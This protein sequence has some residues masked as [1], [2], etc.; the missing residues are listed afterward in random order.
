MPPKVETKLVNERSTDIVV[1][2]QNLETRAIG[3]SVIASAVSTDHIEVRGTGADAG[4]GDVSFWLKKTGVKPGLYNQFK[5]DAY[6]RIIEASYVEGS[7]SGATDATIWNQNLEA[8]A[9]NF[10]I[11]GNGRVNGSLITGSVT[12]GSLSVTGA[13]NFAALTLDEPL[14]VTSGGT[15]TASV[16]A[17]SFFAG[18]V[19]GLN[20]APDW[21]FIAVSDLPPIPFNSLIGLP[22]TLQLHGITDAYT[23]AQVDSLVSGLVVNL[24]DLDDVAVTSPTLN[25]ILKFNGTSWVN[26]DIGSATILNANN[27]PEIQWN[28]PQTASIRV[29]GIVQGGAFA[30]TSNSSAAVEYTWQHSNGW[31][32]AQL[33]VDHSFVLGAYQDFGNGTLTRDPALRVV[34][35]GSEASQIDFLKP[36]TLID[37]TPS[38]TT[39]SLYNDSGALYWNGSPVATGS[40]ALPVASDTVLGGIKVGAGLSIDGAGVLTATGSV[41][42]NMMTTDT[43]QSVTG[44][45][46]F[47]VTGALTAYDVI[48]ST[49]DI[50]VDY[51]DANSN[52]HAYGFNF[53]FNNVYRA[54]FRWNEQYDR[55]ELNV[56]EDNG[57]SRADRMM[58]PR[59]TALP[60]TFGVGGIQ[61]SAGGV[62]LSSSTPSA[63]ANK[64]YNVSGALYWNGAAIGSGASTLSSLTD[65]ALSGNAQYDALMF[66]GTQWANA[67]ISSHSILNANNHPELAWPNYQDASIK[68]TGGIICG[69]H[70]TISKSNGDAVPLSFEHANGRSYIRMNTAHGLELGA[71]NSDGSVISPAIR[72]NSDGSTPTSIDALYVLNA[73]NA[74]AIASYTPSSTSGM[75]Y[76]VSGTLYWN[77]VSLAIPSNMMTTDTAQTVT[78]AKTFNSALSIDP[79][80][81]IQGVTDGSSA[82]TGYVGQVITSSIDSAAAVDLASTAASDVTSITLTPGDWVVDG[83]V[84]FALNAATLSLGES[85]IN[86]TSATITVD[87]REGYSGV[88]QTSASVTIGAPVPSRSIS[89]SANTTV[90]LVALGTF[91]G[92]GCKAF[93]TIRA[94]RVR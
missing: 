23:K 32:Y 1:R 65:V 25:Q 2:R 12:T 33:E 69:S 21:R 40:Y 73:N 47:S 9:A 46:N 36:I 86:T 61:V 66:N 17:K 4:T 90:Y 50:Y 27:Y 74:I 82:S 43:A 91:A 77:G 7:G 59:D 3:K 31:F 60:I 68:I 49:G 5:T 75:L 30:S 72:V 11:S 41:P 64:L 29:S 42:S 57:V 78:G 48:V 76:N 38:V 70:V 39:G 81:G 84:N 34:T 51:T 37:A 8:Q 94:Q 52:V 22:N 79:A 55:F 62:L 19:N 18:P 80:Y 45:K 26:S 14:A 6:G 20:D 87:G 63:T 85:A 35:N 54:M 15:G 24:S 67:P 28:A 10:W 88:V 92:T 13:V 71:Y 93:G 89:V 44:A 58:V 56:R 53:R 83:S 16:A